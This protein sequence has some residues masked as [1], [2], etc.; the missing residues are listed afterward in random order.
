MAE[1]VKEPAVKPDDLTLIAWTYVLT[2]LLYC[3]CVHT[4]THLLKILS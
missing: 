1:Q 2:K 3:A 4:P